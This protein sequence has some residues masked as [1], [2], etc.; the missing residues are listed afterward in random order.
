MIA[1][2]RGFGARGPL[3]KF[4]PFKKKK[5][6]FKLVFKAWRSSSPSVPVCVLNLVLIRRQ[7]SVPRL[8]VHLALALAHYSRGLLG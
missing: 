6:V 7:K 3:F 5:T 8:V 1:A 4:G 2:L